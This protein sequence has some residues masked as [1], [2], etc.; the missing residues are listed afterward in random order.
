MIEEGLWSSGS[1]FP[2]GLWLICGTMVA[3]VAK[4]AEERGFANLWVFE[5]LLFPTEPSEG[6][7]GLPG[8]PW[9][10][11]YREVADPLVIL[12][13]A[14][15]VTER[16]RIGSSVLVTPLHIPVRLAKALGTID[17]VSGGRLVGGVG[18]CWSNDEF[19]AA[20]SPSRDVDHSSTKPWT[21]SRRCGL[22]T[23]SPSMVKELRWT[24]RA[25][26]RFGCDAGGTPDARGAAAGRGSAKGGCPTNGGCSAKRGCA[27]S[28]VVVVV[29]RAVAGSVV[30]SIAQSLPP[31]PAPGLGERTRFRP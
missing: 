7:Y 29:V 14:A 21:C 15:A 31:H 28:V 5:R 1:A 25:S 18:S 6:L 27:A 4:F 3:A 22:P 12:A 20:V 17:S 9:P 23:L 11:G 24:G 8:L 19:A 2:N 13:A 30:C 16:V 10:E 26:G